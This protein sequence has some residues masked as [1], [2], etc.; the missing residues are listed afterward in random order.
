MTFLKN[1]WYAAGWSDEVNG[2]QPLAR[3]IADVPLVIFR[4]SDGS[5]TALV[6]RCP[7]RFA[8]LSKGSIR[9]DRLQC[10][11]H[12]LTFDASGRCVGN[13]HGPPVRALD[14]PAYSIS[15]KHGIIWVWLGNKQAVHTAPIPDL[16]TVK[17]SPPT[18]F[19]RGYIPTA[20][21]HQ[22]LVDNILDASHA[23][24]L[25]ADQLGGGW[26]TRSLLRHED[27]PHGV[28][29]EWLGRNEKAMPI[30]RP[31]LPD[32]EMLTDSWLQVMWYPSGAMLLSTG[33]TAPGA[34]WEGGIVTH[35]AHIMTPE[36]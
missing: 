16:S 18:A 36:S 10:G 7:H 34:P 15:E 30:F 22:L 24:Y 3:T 25:H 26:M 27:R 5:C 31:E 29:A 6:D 12:G 1:V 14:I 32:P 13:P 21:N 2:H 20:A 35:A 8:P 28:F 17:C 23:D 33:A 4:L 9:Q 11:Y 19:I